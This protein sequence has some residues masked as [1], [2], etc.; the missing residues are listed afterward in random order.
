MVNGTDELITKADKHD[1][2]IYFGQ[3]KYFTLFRGHIIQTFLVPISQRFLSPI[4]MFAS[5]IN[6]SSPEYFLKHIPSDYQQGRP[7]NTTFMSS[8][9]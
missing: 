3:N 4:F 2:L 8:F 6:P 1:T 5:V 7:S 9:H